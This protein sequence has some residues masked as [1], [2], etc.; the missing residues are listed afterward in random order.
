MEDTDYTKKYVLHGHIE[1]F[2]NGVKLREDSGWYNAI[3]PI[4]RRLAGFSKGDYVKLTYV[5]KPKTRCEGNWTNLYAIE[6]SEEP[7]NT[8][9]TEEEPND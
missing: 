3:R 8:E 7:K 2:H 1:G 4:D 9:I 5:L 6:H